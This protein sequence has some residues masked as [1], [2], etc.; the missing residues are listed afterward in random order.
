MTLARVPPG[1]TPVSVSCSVLTSFVRLMRSCAEPLKRA[2]QQYGGNL[3]K[4]QVECDRRVA[5]CIVLQSVNN[6]HA[7]L[8]LGRAGFEIRG[9]SGVSKQ[10]LQ[11][12]AQL[13]QRR[14]RVLAL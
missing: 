8:K 7:L 2:Q 13:S 4:T 6:R 1:P 9:Q 12:A 10:P 3:I 11:Q 5:A 14:D